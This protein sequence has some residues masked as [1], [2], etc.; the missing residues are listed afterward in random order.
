LD[1]ISFILVENTDKEYKSSIVIDLLWEKV[2]LISSYKVWDVVKASLNFRTSD[3]NWRYFN[4][5]SAWRIDTLDGSSPAPVN[6][7]KKEEAEDE[8]LPF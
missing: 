4:N 8:D 7:T 5:I 1:K 6:N 2:D 3:Y